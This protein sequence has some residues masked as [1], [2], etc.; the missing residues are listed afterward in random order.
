[1]KSTS[2]IAHTC[3]SAS[4]AL[5]LAG[6]AI[7]QSTPVDPLA[8]AA[9]PY[10]PT[11]IHSFTSVSSSWSMTQ[12]VDGRTISVSSKDGKIAAD[13]D[14]TPVPD[15]RIIQKSGSVRINDEKGESIFETAVPGAEPIVRAGTTAFPRSFGS[16]GG[17]AA[18]GGRISIASPSDRTVH[19]SMDAPKVMVGVQLV[20]PDSSLRGHLGLKEDETTLISA[21]YEGLPAA[22]AGLEPY[23]IVVAINGKPPASPELVRKSLRETEPGKSI[24]LDIIHRGAKKTVTITVEKYDEQK[25]ESAKVNSIAASASSPSTVAIAGDPND[26]GAATSWSWGGGGRNPFVATVPGAP[27][28]PSKSITLWGR[29][30]ADQEGMAKRLEELAER[31]K[32]Q[33]QRSDEQVKR[34]HEQMMGDA[35]GGRNMM[36]LNRVM[37]E[38]MKKME[39]MMQRMME[40]RNTP[41]V[42]ATTP[43]KDEPKS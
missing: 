12:S 40:Q 33:A 25:L 23:D 27:G 2:R 7:A 15:D 5:A 17:P 29:S 28:Q 18:R 20:E 9:P 8:P 1:M 3:W 16:L 22:Q 36:D 11:P 24:A 13:V 35:A 6:T 34:L 26:P 4:A 43:K 30:G 31:A 19:M 21:V 32:E 38:R 10:P 39:E 42:P 37:D 41:P 14:G